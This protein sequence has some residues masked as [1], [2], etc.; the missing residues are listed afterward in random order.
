MDRTRGQVQ[1][2]T[3]QKDIPYCAHD[4]AGSG[5]H[6]D[7]LYLSNSTDGRKVSVDFTVERDGAIWN[8]NPGLTV[9]CCNHAERHTAWNGLKNGQINQASVGI[10]IVQKVDLSL[11]PLYPEAQVQSVAKLCAWL[12]SNFNLKPAEIVTHRQIITNG[13]RSDPRKFPFDGDQGF[14]FF[15]WQS[16]GHEKNFVNSMTEKKITA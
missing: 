11:K 10:E 16:C 14:W 15:F 8:L 4:T 5:K 1:K 9:K 6:G 13:S 12:V 3:N 7:T 2:P